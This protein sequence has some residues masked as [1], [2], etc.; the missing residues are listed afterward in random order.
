MTTEFKAHNLSWAIDNMDWRNETA[1][2]AATDLL[3]DAV[4]AWDGVTAAKIH[5]L[6][7][8]DDDCSFA[9][10][11]HHKAESKMVTVA[12]CDALIAATKDWVR[13]PDT[14]HNLQLMARA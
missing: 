1:R 11:D 3:R 2:D 13:S 5:A 7:L 9:N 12:Q 14:G 10:G 8:A 6:L 4:V